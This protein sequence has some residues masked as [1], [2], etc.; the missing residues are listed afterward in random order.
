MSVIIVFAGGDPVPRDI[1][2]D[3]PVP[4]Q[5]IAADSGY[6]NAEV[7]GF[8]VDVVIGDFDSLPADSDFPPGVEKI[9]YPT[10][11]DAT[12]LELAFEF[13][14][15]A[16]GQRIV[17]VGGEGGRFDHEV[18]TTMLLGSPQWASVPDVEWVRSD[19]HCYVVRDAKRIQGDPGAT[20][21]LISIA[22]DA[23]NVSTEGLEWD[24]AS[25]TIYQ[26]STRGVSNRFTSLEAVVRVG[27]GA[28]LAVVP[29]GG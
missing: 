19:A 27:S 26:G 6:R 21:S 15:S 1:L 3:L 23:T 25:E 2:E 14:R 11:K 17:L 13:A 16:D 12:D 10:D 22:G 29:Q 18:A 4:D 28:L 9:S 7:L 8:R 20:I 5:V 24:L